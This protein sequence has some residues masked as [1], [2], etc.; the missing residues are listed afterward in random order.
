MADTEE[1]LD[2]LLAKSFFGRPSAAD[3]VAPFLQV[4]PYELTGELR[5]HRAHADAPP[6]LE[7]AWICHETELVEWRAV[8]TVV[9]L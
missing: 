6:V 5:W 2:E 7:Q 3:L 4:P 8:E 9:E 1:T